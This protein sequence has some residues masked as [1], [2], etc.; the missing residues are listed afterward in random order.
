MIADFRIVPEAGC[1]LMRFSGRV[2][3]SRMVEVFEAYLADPAF[4]GAYHLLMDLTGS[5][6]EESAYNDALRLAHRLRPFYERRAATSRTAVCAPDDTAFGMARM[7]Q[8][9][10]EGQRPFET[11]VFQTVEEAL[12]FL[13]IAPEAAS[14]QRLTAGMAES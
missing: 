2:G 6:C 12:R 4:D 13:D 3:M 1:T 14:A 7:F 9:A 10:T 8:G 5:A 11:G